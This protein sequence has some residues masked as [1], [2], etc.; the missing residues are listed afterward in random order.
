MNQAPHNRRTF[1]KK[2]LTGI[3]GPTLIPA[4]AWGKEKTPPSERIHVGIVGLGGIGMGHVGRFLRDKNAHV[5]AVCD[6]HKIHYRDME[7]EK[8]EACGRDAGKALVERYFAD[9]MKQGTYKGCDAYLDYRELCTRDDIDAVV[10]ATPDHWHAH[11]TLEALRNGKDVY[12]EKPVTHLFAEGQA[13]VAEVARQNAIFQ[14]GSQQRSA[15]K[16]KQYVE[17]VRNGHLGKIKR[18]EVG[19][20]T[21]PTQPLGDPT[22]TEVPEHL[23][24]EMWCGPSEVLP[25]MRARHHRYWRFHRSYGGGNLMDWIG[26][27]NDIAHWGMDVERSGP[28]SV[29]AVGQWTWPEFKG[30]N[31]PV[32]Y[33]IECTY[34]GD[35]TTNISNKN[36]NGIKWIGED[37]WLWADRGSAEAS[38]P[39]WL[40]RKFGPGPIEV[41]ES[42]NHVA[43]FI[44]GIKT[45]KECIA[46]AVIGHRS[47]TPGHLGYVSQALGRKVNWDADTET[48][49]DDNEAHTLLKALNYRDG[50]SL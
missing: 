5:V 22:V 1:A 8:R 21:G 15:F 26:H 4:G 31:G 42:R 39:R 44:E 43:N 12:C 34:A 29:E 19:L 30:Y 17:V 9:E 23:D 47:I 45:R 27:H 32:D 13:V 10:V 37:G 36:K 16:F 24:Y 14:T 40:D 18:V 38:D 48:V 28:E 3:L 46:P 33:E 6:V 41:Y 35:I 49:I 50:W 2:V 7:W 11:C 20:P 25:Y